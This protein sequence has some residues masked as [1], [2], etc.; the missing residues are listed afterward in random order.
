MTTTNPTTSS[1]TMTSQAAAQLAGLLKQCEEFLT[2]PG[3]R[4]QL[5]EFCLPRPTVSSGWLIDMLAWHALHL[6]AKIDDPTPAD[7]QDRP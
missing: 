4:A 6:H 5:A 1:I 7:P 3:V 2:Q